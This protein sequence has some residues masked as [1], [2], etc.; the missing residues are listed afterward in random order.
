MKAAPFEYGQAQNLDEALSLLADSGDDTMII[1]GGQT[2]VPMMAMRLARPTFLVDINQV[3]EL[4]GM[5]AG[6]GV[7]QIGARTRQA[8]ALADPGLAENVPLLAKA[9]SFVGHVQTRN[10]GTIGGS[11]AHGDPAAEIPLTAVA[12][13]AQLT[14]KSRTGE[15]NL[16]AGEFIEG[17]MMT[18][19]GADECLT[20]I[21]FPIWADEGT[22]GI[23]FQEVSERHGDFAI[24]AVAVQ[25]LLDEGGICRRVAIA[26]GGAHPTP[27][28]IKG[29]EELL[30]GQ[31]MTPEAMEAAAAEA[32]AVLEPDGDT[33]ASAGYRRG[34]ARRLTIRAFQEASGT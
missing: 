30:Q 34:V 13:D 20:R 8:K 33:H 6:D 11:L 25:L 7:W 18:T 4:A 28:R 31:S 16:S 14:L 21:D 10:R 3:D 17:P 27:L 2:L 29:A 5:E 26:V 32:E 22:L 15:R 19:R 1:A 12:L 9:L 23:G 24:V